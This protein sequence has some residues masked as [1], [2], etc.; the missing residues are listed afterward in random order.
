MTHLAPVTRAQ[1]PPG[2]S[3]LSCVRHVAQT[4]P[5]SPA[6]DRYPDAPGR[7]QPARP[8]KP[9][10]RTTSTPPPSRSE[11]DGHGDPQEGR[12]PRSARSSTS[13]AFASSGHTQK[14][15]KRLPPTSSARKSDR[16]DKE[17]AKAGRTES[18]PR[19]QAPPSRPSPSPASWNSAAFSNERRPILRGRS[20]ICLDYTGDPHG[21]DAQR[22]RRGHPR[23]GRDRLG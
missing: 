18:R 9:S 7:G 22:A 14:D 5:D 12:K 13:T 17:I 15:G 11:L 21:K 3:P 20:T 10:F 6:R 19:L 1:A 23:H 8:P 4:A 16:I 2:K